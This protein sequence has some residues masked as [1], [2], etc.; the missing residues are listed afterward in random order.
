MT[1]FFTDCTGQHTFS[2]DHVVSVSNYHRILSVAAN[3]TR[4]PRKDYR[5]DIAGYE[6][7]IILSVDGREHKLSIFFDRDSEEKRD[8]E[9]RRLSKALSDNS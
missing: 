6:I 2:L 1:K 3:P 7:T 9:F 8:A 4:P 5:D